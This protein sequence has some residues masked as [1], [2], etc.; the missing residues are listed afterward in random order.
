MH[1]VI[2]G[3][4]PVAIFYECFKEGGGLTDVE[5]YKIILIHGVR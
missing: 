5:G 3:Y 1:S 2:S 4:N